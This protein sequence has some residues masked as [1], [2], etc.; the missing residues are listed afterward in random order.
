MIHLQSLHMHKFLH[1]HLP[2]LILKHRYLHHL[3]DI[4]R[5]L[6]MEIKMQ[7]ILWDDAM[8]ME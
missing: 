5:Q 4:K 6:E 2:R 8:N 3:I 7:N 1:Y